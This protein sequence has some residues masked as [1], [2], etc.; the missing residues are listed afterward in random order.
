MRGNLWSVVLAGG[1]GRR[2]SR[3]TGGVP[4][5]FW[6]PDGG[7]SLLESTIDRLAPICPS[8]RTIVVVGDAHREHV[9]RWPMYRSRGRILLQ[10]DDRGTAAG[11]LLG[12]LPVLAA[13]PDGV[14]VVTPAD[15][16]VRKPDVFRQGI[17]DAIAHAQHPGGVVL[18]GVEPEA[19]RDDYGWITLDPASPARIRAVTSFVEKPSRDAASRLLASGAVWNSMVM[20]ARARHLIDLCATQQP[21][22]TGV[23]QQAVGLSS[24]LRYAFLAGRYAAIEPADLSRDVLSR[25]RGLWAYTWPAALG[26]SDLGTPERLSRWMEQSRARADRVAAPA[27]ATREIPGASFAAR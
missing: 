15:H 7:R 20:V 25:A 10:P 5:Q 8:D 12:L 16:G 22:L 11:L 24:R 9:R 14:V 18:F 19:P 23:F 3:I 26:W 1:A 6:R 21:H 17:V 2:L 13:D 27:A 4:K